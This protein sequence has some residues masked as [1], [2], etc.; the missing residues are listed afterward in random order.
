MHWKM[1]RDIGNK[2][3]DEE[4]GFFGGYKVFG[5]SSPLWVALAQETQGPSKVTGSG[6]LSDEPVLFNFNVYASDTHEAEL[7]RHSHAW[8][9]GMKEWLNR[10]P[11]H[12]AILLADV[13]GRPWSAKSGRPLASTHIA[14]D[15]LGLLTKYNLQYRRAAPHN[16]IMLDGWTLTA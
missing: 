1:I 9:N 11:Y 4:K 2:M 3:T 15:L 5:D 16:F 10:D 12:W 8:L 7:V 13:S 14:D 6:R